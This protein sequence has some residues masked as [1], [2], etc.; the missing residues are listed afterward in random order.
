VADGVMTVIGGILSST[1]TINNEGTPGLSTVP[2]LGWLFKRQSTR[3][4]SQELLI[5]ITPRIIR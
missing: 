1:E 5:F 4:E 3:N 2:L